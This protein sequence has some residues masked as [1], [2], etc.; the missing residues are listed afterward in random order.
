V[1][2]G[3]NLTRA[4]SAEAGPGRLFASFIQVDRFEVENKEIM[5]TF[6]TMCTFEKT[7]LPLLR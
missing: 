4:R 1:R 5:V 7:F 2:V 3:V 6:V